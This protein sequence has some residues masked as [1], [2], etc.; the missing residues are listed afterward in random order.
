MSAP[1][2]AFGCLVPVGAARAM[3]PTGEQRTHDRCTSGWAACKVSPVSPSRRTDTDMHELGRVDG[4]GVARGLLLQWF[5]C[6]AAAATA[7]RIYDEN[8][9]RRLCETRPRRNLARRATRCVG[10]SSVWLRSDRDTA[11][12]GADRA[13]AGHS[14]RRPLR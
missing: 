11:R 7:G 9:N 10:L 14:P 4:L 2:L 3:P 5:E 1:F 6:R 13:R 8:A 12:A